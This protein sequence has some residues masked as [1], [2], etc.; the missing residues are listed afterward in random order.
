MSG[1]TPLEL[2]TCLPVDDHALLRAET[3]RIGDV[4]R[5][6]AEEYPR[7]DERRERRTLDPVDRDDHLS[8][9]T[10]GPRHARGVRA[11]HDSGEQNAVVAIARLPIDDHVRRRAVFHGEGQALRIGAEDRAGKHDRWV[12][13][14]RDAVDG[15]AP[16]ASRT[17]AVGEASRVGTEPHAAAAD[18]FETP[19]FLSVHDHEVR[20][21]RAHG[22]HE[23]P[24]V[25]A[26]GH[27]AHP[28][29]RDGPPR[30]PAPRPSGFPSLP[31]R[32]SGP[33]PH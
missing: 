24:R 11:E 31:R 33:S 29:M 28:L 18:A 26:E 5:V 6:R 2:G 19:P 10:G 22:V 30:R 9:S 15:D 1:T 25:G 4:S 13:S 7:L 21:V 32:R 3:R 16:C 23:L 20:A 27:I 12:R 17:D 14:S 8:G